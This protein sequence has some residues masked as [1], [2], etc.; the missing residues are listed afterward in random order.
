M[1]EASR[2][3]A[4]SG[5]SEA[6]AEFFRIKFA[7]DVDS[8]LIAYLESPGKRNELPGDLLKPALL[9]L[10][11]SGTVAALTDEQV[12]EC[13]ERNCRSLLKDLNDFKAGD[14]QVIAE[15]AKNAITRL[16]IC[17][18]SPAAIRATFTGNAR[19]STAPAVAKPLPQAAPSRAAKLPV[20]APIVPQAVVPQ[21]S[22]PEAAPV[23]APIVAMPIRKST[24]KKPTGLS[25]SMLMAGIAGL[26]LVVVVGAIVFFNM[27]KEQPIARPANKQPSP[28]ATTAVAPPENPTAIPAKP[29]EVPPVE[30]KPKSSPSI[31][32]TEPAPAPPADPPK[33][34]D[35][36]NIPEPP[37][38]PPQNL[39][40]VPETPA[41]DP[42]VKK[43]EVDKAEFDRMR[44]SLREAVKDTA[45][46]EKVDAILAF[47]SNPEIIKSPA[48]AK[49][50]LAEALV[51]SLATKDV[52]RAH[53]TLDRI[54]KASQLF[55]DNEYY[56]SVTRVKNLAVATG[57]RAVAFELID[58]LQQWKVISPLDAFAEK[59]AALN[60]AAAD[61]ELKKPANQAQ[62]QELAD[63]MVA[64]ALAAA[65]VRPDLAESLLV[66]AR[67]TAGAIIDREQ[68]AAFE[69]ELADAKAVAAEAQRY[70]QAVEQLAK[71]P[72]NAAARKVR[73][74][75]LLNR[76]QVQPALGD[77]ADI[78]HPLQSL[79]QET[80]PLLQQGAAASGKACFAGAQ[81]WEKAAE[82]AEGKKRAGLQQLAHQLITLAIAAKN[83]PLDPF[84]LQNA[85]Q[86]E[87]TFAE[88]PV[89]IATKPKTVKPDPSKTATS[90]AAKPGP[91]ERPG[92]K[93]EPK[94][95]RETIVGTWSVTYASGAKRTYRVDAAGNVLYVETRQLGTL[96]QRGEDLVLD[97]RDGKM[98]RWKLD[99]GL[100]RIDHFDPASRYP[101]TVS[102]TASGFREKQ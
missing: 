53:T 31:S 83:E 10:G 81:K 15:R 72:T 21:A 34:I 84:A 38:D 43:V 7:K 46:S 6:L 30:T 14:K 25:G 86:L 95:P 91:K 96:M 41:S 78:D 3:P 19:R 47:A 100:L 29:P 17:L 26:G 22:I 48:A 80:K 28:K 37:V 23:I 13:V 50:V 85:K 42:E 24:T 45:E 35:P 68:R 33:T 51:Q 9:L 93:P 92:R 74:D 90:T 73:V 76:G 82:E 69:K 49:A 102:Q 101:N 66:E 27:P 1:P 56:G 63:E 60:A 89:E 61:K 16:G 44:A 2:E 20:G 54:R 12:L 18:Q 55:A 77:L 79:A 99:S 8:K 40:N 4:K 97:M 88:T 94:E 32:S 87:T 39:V 5:G 62:R 59:S 75:V 98:E 58:H 67:K 71:D 70:H 36:L 52:G 65:E 57:E 64:L 11:I